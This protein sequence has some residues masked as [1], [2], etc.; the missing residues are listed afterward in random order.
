MNIN[1]IRLREND[2]RHKRERSHTEHYYI[3]IVKEY[4]PIVFLCYDWICL[5]VNR[6]T[7]LT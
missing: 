1:T 4:I 7:I 6:L 5:I 2:L 3:G